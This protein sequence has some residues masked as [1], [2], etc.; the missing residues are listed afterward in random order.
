VIQ[1]IVAQALGT[2]KPEA[3]VNGD[4]VINIFDLVSVAN[5]F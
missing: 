3:D 2:D 1:S 4:G 5:Q